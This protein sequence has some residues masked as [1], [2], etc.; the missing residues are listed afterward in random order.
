M[1]PTLITFEQPLNECIRICL[2]LEHLFQQFHT[3]LKVHTFS[4]QNARLAIS[5]LIELLNVIDRPDLKSRLTQTLTQ[6]VSTLTQLQQSTHIDQ[7]HLQS[8]LTKL[9]PLTNQLHSTHTKIAE[10][11]RN[12]DFLSSVRTQVHNPGG[13]CDFAL[14][15]FACWLTRDNEEQKQQLETWF[16]EFSLLESITEIILELTRESAVPEKLIATEAFY[17]RT[18]NP[19]TPVQ[20]IRISLPSALNLYPELSVGKHRLSIHFMETNY[21]DGKRLP[22]RRADIEF[23]LCCCRI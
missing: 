6:N 17:Q 15:V 1:Q 11:L 19:N 16:K 22:L 4:E 21:T 10:D 20:L 2:R 9:D 7:N 14:P 13:I 12:N 18:L 23:E 5:I 3:S 8:I